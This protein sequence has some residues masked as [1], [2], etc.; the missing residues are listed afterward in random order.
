MVE[1]RRVRNAMVVAH[2][3][4]TFRSKLELYCYKKLVELGVEFSYEEVK[5]DL[6]SSLALNRVRAFHPIKSGKRKGEWQEIFKI[7]KKSYTPDF[8]IPN[9]HGYY[10]VFECKGFENDDFSSKRKLFLSKLEDEFGNT[11]LKPIYLEPH[12]QRQ[13]NVCIDFIKTLE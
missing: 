9:Y 6:I 1:N 11:E 8:I 7:N 2:D 4:R 12:T 10:I 13:V 3:G 5:F